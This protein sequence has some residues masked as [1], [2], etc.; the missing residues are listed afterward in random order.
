[1]LVIRKR[2]ISTFATDWTLD[3]GSYGLFEPASDAS[4][5]R[6]PS[7]EER[8]AQNLMQNG[9][10]CSDALAKR[11]HHLNPGFHYPKQ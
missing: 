4:R 3:R 1:M 11:R 10:K 8:A 7:D 5:L 2:Y 9:V 6:L